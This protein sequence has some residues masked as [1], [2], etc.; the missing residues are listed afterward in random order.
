MPLP[1]NAGNDVAVIL[2]RRK[3]VADLYLQG[4]TQA[5]VGERLLC[6][7]TTVCEDLKHIREEWQTRASETFNEKV[8]LELAKIDQVE[9]EAWKA[10]H[11]SCGDAVTK[12]KKVEK[13]LRKAKQEQDE[14]EEG[15]KPAFGEPMGMV[16]VKTLIEMTRKGQV[17][18]PSFLS[19]VLNCVDMRLKV[20]GAYKEP[21][22][23]KP[24]VLIIDWKQM[25]E[26][27]PI[28]DPLDEALK[29]LPPAPSGS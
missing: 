17:G 2:A 10:Y 29:S 26:P 8:M 11:R 27:S 23:A 24:N 12:V 20:L 9:A 3:Q 15:D 1:K 25:N 22:T 16:P 14:Q 7:Q 13:A 5:E 21:P 4:L 18:N 19:M 6:S 28:T